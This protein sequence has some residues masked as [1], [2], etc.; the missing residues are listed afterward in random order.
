MSTPVISPDGKMQWDGTQWIPLNPNTNIIQDSVVMGD[1]KTEINYQ[2]NFSTT[3]NNISTDNNLLIRSHLK[4]ML[5]KIRG[6]RIE[7]GFMLL[8]NAK[9]IDYDLAEKMFRDDF[10]PHVI[11]A[12]YQHTS[13]FC[14]Q[15][16]IN[17]RASTNSRTRSFELNQFSQ[18]YNNAVSKINWILE[19]DPKHIPS[20]FLLIQVVNRNSKD[21]T[22][23]KRHK[24]LI[25][26][27]QKIITLDNSNLEAKKIHDS[28]S[29]RIKL[30]LL[31][32]AFGI[33]C[34]IAPLILS[35]SLYNM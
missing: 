25:R 18:N 33:G 19:L 20:L 24:E 16:V 34:L 8:E 28:S 5:D 26:I 23:F 22:F 21:F 13:K 29:K 4:S 32:I 11:Q 15:F 2:Q 3:V 6:N 9:L 10:L 27:A 1:L 7:E 12:L 17:F 14:H 35:L 31:G 30:G